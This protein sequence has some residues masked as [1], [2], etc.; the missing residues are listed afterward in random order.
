MNLIKRYSDI[1]WPVISKINHDHYEYIINLKN[2]I[3]KVLLFF[4]LE[5]SDVSRT[6]KPIPYHIVS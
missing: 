6:R 3:Q 4:V 2:E 1:A 5:S